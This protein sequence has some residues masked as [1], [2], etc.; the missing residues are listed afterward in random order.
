MAIE[1]VL[2]QVLKARADERAELVEHLIDS[3]ED[4][5]I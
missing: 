3:L 5:E 4:E 1:A 2:K